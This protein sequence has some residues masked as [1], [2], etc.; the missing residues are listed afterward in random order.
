MNMMTSGT[1]SKLKMAYQR[2]WELIFN[3]INLKNN[4]KFDFRDIEIEL[5]KNLPA[6]DDERIDSTLKL[7]GIV[8]DQT[9]IEKLGFDYI[10]EKNRMEEEAK[11]DFNQN[12]DNIRNQQN[13]NNNQETNQEQEVVT[14]E[15]REVDTEEVAT[16][17]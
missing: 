3:R 8:S 11:E 16:K 9:V 6:N 13:M 4:T 15:T 5:P 17:E 10:N 12:L 14:E 1:I 2:R 7:H